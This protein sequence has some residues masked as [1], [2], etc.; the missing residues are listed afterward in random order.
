M[1]AKPLSL[2]DS[3]SHNLGL[4]HLRP[5]EAMLTRQKF[6]FINKHP[7]RGSIEHLDVN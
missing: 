3:G 4:I 1:L 5:P 2:K 6:I 7:T